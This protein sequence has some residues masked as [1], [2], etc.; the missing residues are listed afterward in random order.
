MF[1]LVAFLL[2]AFLFNFLSFIF[3]A[4]LYNASLSR[5]SVLFLQLCFLFVNLQARREIQEKAVKI[6]EIAHA[7]EKT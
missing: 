1:L 3:F 6:N 7:M 5:E 2:A 4:F